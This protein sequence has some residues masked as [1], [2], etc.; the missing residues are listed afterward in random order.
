MNKQDR[1]EIYKN[2]LW[3]YRKG[4]WLN[5]SKFKL[6]VAA[7][8]CRYFCHKDIRLVDLYELDEQ[9]PKN[10]L[11]NASLWFPNGD[12]ALRIECLKKAIKLCK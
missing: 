12:L 3:D 10:K 9:R 5:F 6:Y 7:G 11:S 2:A 8:F 4:Y 1:L